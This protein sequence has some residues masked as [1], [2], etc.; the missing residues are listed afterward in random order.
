MTLEAVEASLVTLSGGLSLADVSDAVG[1]L[2]WDFGVGKVA[3]VT[4]PAV[5]VDRALL[6]RGLL[7]EG[8][9]LTY[10][11]APYQVAAVER[12][13]KG[14]SVWLSVQA[15]SRLARR[16]RNLTGPRRW[17]NATPQT[18]I[19]SLVKRAGGVA[20]VEPGAKRRTVNQKRTVGAL[21]LI[22][23]LASDT[24]VEWVE[25]DGQVFV[26]TPWWAFQGK[27][28]LPTWGAA[29]DGS[30]TLAR[31]DLEVTAFSA[32]SS[33]DDRGQEASASLSVLPRGG[34]RLRPWHRV[35][36]QKAD[37]AD[38]GV[39][40]VTNV[41]FDEAKSSAVSVTLSRPVKASPKKGSQGSPGG[42]AAGSDAPIF[43]GGGGDWVANADKVP[44]GCARSPRAWVA[45]AKSR[46]GDYYEPNRCAR[47]VGDMTGW[48][49][50]NAW[51]YYVRASRK[52]PGDAD[53]PIGSIVTWKPTGPGDGSPDWSGAGHGSIWGHVGIAIGGGQFIS[54]T[55]GSVQIDSLRGW[56]VADG[57]FGASL[58]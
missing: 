57:Y 22:E 10:D 17:E 36:V 54:A 28:G 31:R 20:V 55:G 29:V 32:R 47:W 14:V 26:G 39:W 11:G 19:T 5:D 38:N 50:G 56:G 51:A 23:S 33:L 58:P 52:S 46:V 48:R 40:L 45:L 4:I 1:V 7:A 21:A 30:Y 24:G 3:E 2:S 18:V 34:V 37:R 43:D 27:T 41:S 6:K 12:D 8:T 15:R 25:F 35:E 42:S 16:L 49:P 9:T 53:P 13:Y 44:A